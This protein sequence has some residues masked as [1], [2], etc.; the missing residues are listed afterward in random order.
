MIKAVLF[1]MD[2]TVFDTEVI[3]R[4]CW[5]RAAE[6]VGFDEDMDLFF[7]RVGGLNLTD[8]ADLFHRV[9]GDSVPFEVLWARWLACIDDEMACDVLPFKAGA[10]EILFALKEQGIKIALV[11]SSGHKTVARY[12]QM[13]RLESVFD[14]IMTGDRVTHGK[15][16]PEIFLSAAEKLGIAPEHCVVIEDSPNGIKAGHAAGMYT[17]MVPDLHPCTKELEALLWHRCDTLSDLIPLIENENK[18]L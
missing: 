1:D 4:R 3:Y 13:S 2:G 15:P 10:P 18:K 16:H 8:M 14:V 6:D 11:T 12:L 9:Y 17:V 5:F 7:E